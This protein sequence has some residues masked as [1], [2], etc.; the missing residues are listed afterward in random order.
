[1]QSHIWKWYKNI[2]SHTFKWQLQVVEIFSADA[3]NGLSV[4]S[5]VLVCDL[6]S[7]DIINNVIPKLNGNFRSFGSCS[8]L[9]YYYILYIY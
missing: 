3:S 4:F 6:F 8:P 2:T 1:M 5:Q 9:L 7:Y